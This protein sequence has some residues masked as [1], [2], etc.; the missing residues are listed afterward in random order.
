MAAV[1][2]YADLSWVLPGWKVAAWLQQRSSDAG[3]HWAAQAVNP[4]LWTESWIS[5]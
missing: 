2:G 4:L 1:M 5:S 3:G